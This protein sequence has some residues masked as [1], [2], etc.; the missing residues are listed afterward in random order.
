M[1]AA[2][3]LAGSHFSM[4]SVRNARV[5]S[6]TALGADHGLLGA[7]RGLLQVAAEGGVAV[8]GDGAQGRAGLAGLDAAAILAEQRPTVGARDHLRERGPERAAH[9]G[10]RGVGRIQDPA[11]AGRAEGGAGVSGERGRMGYN[12]DIILPLS[13]NFPGNW[14]PG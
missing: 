3:T 6:E 1:L 9:L 2:E 12:K 10:E 11:E 5:W 13:P 7:D 8:A 14:L 4:V